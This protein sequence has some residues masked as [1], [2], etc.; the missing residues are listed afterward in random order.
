MKAEILGSLHPKLAG[1]TAKDIRRME[2]R[3]WMGD[4]SPIS[5]GPS[6]QCYQTLLGFA[7]EHRL[8]PKI[9]RMYQNNCILPL[10]GSVGWHTDEGIGLIL[11]W[12]IH[13]TS[14]SRKVD[15]NDMQLIYPNGAIDVRLGDVFLFNGNQGHAWCSNNRCTLVQ[16]T[17]IKT[18]LKR[19]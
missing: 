4:V 7:L 19:G 6:N 8:R 13:K 14:L 9:R 18:R 3:A 17:V 2:Q 11:N 5:I 12:I 1:L 15:P 10:A 16:M